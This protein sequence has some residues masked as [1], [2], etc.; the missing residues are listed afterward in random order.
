MDHSFS[1]I[2]ILIILIVLISGGVFTWRH[3]KTQKEEVEIPIPEGGVKKSTK[4]AA[5]PEGYQVSPDLIF[6]TPDSKQ[7]IFVAHKKPDEAV[8]FINNEKIG[9][10]SNINRHV[11][12]GHLILEGEKE[13]KHFWIIDGKVYGPYVYDGGGT[14]RLTPDGKHFAFTALK[15]KWGAEGQSVVINDNQGEFY[16]DVSFPVFS[17]DGNHYAYIGL[18][19]DKNK[20]FVILDGE[21]VGAHLDAS[22]PT[23]SPDSKHFAYI[24]EDTVENPLGGEYIISYIV[25]DGEKKYKFDDISSFAFDENGKHIKYFGREEFGKQWFLIIDGRKVK[26]YNFDFIFL[27][28][29]DYYQAYNKTREYEKGGGYYKDYFLVTNDKEIGPYAVSP[30][31]LTFSPNSE[32]FAFI[33]D[34]E[35]KE[36]IVIDGEEFGPYDRVGLFAFSPD[37]E[38]FAYAAM[39]EGKSFIV[40][41]GKESKPFD[42]PIYNVSF[43]FSSDSKHLAYTAVREG[44]QF[45][46]IDGKEGK[47]Y[48]GVSSFTFS[49]DSKHS[50]YIAMK[51]T[52]MEWALGKAKFF[53]VLDGKKGKIY[54]GIYRLIFSPD[55]RYI[56]YGAEI[57][58]EFWWIVDEVE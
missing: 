38:H 43:T 30:A 7:V 32:H 39:K 50:A 46:V 53:I 5:I 22:S 49:P 40:I 42:T 58:N 2:W 52:L 47:T 44:K 26:S 16:D 31:N 3:W 13:G 55:G 25:L 15:G 23:F 33:G 35:K 20:R 36:F 10:Y 11:N 8:V 27:L 29:W 37:S 6:F 56:G 18:K 28:N 51:G 14:F 9:A 45:V 21:I 34:K 19:K 41:D 4:L 17:P 1:K 48:D 54:D 12:P 24:A 57:D